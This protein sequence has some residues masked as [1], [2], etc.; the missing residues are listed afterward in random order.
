MVCSMYV[1]GD[2]NTVLAAV[3]AGES[4]ALL[5]FQ[6]AVRSETGAVLMY[7]IIL[8]MACACAIGCFASASRMAWS[9][10]R[11]NA[12]PFSDWMGKVCFLFSFPLFS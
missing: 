4:P 1:M 11:D 8:I 5:I 9:F 6:Q 7:V 2:F 3:E 12:L 10:A